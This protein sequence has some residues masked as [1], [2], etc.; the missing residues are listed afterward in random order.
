MEG[1]R[2]AVKGLFPS[3]QPQ[4]QSIYSLPLQAGLLLTQLALTFLLLVHH[5]AT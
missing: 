5:F 2:N 3:M 1:G 4:A